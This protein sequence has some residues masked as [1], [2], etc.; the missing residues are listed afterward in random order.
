MK[1]KEVV[2]D[3][4]AEMLLTFNKEGTVGEMSEGK[5]GGGVVCFGEPAFCGRVGHAAM[6]AV[7]RGFCVYV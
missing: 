4:D 7:S 2:A 6:I 1:V 3:G 5:V